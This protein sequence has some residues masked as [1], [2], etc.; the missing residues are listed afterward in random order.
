MNSVQEKATASARGSGG[1]WHKPLR[2][3]AGGRGDA[4]NIVLEFKMKCFS[5][6]SAVFCVISGL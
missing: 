3:F 6:L 1:I 2:G 4:V 5:F